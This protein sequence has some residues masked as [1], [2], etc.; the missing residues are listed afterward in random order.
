[1]KQSKA[2]LKSKVKKETEIGFAIVS[3]LR[4]VGY[5]V[6][7]EV[8]IGNNY[9]D[10]VAVKD[11]TITAIELKISFSLD[12]IAQAKDLLPNFNAVYVGVGFS[13]PSRARKLAMEICS[14]FGIGVI[15]VSVS[16]L[17][18]GYSVTGDLD[19]KFKS[20]NFY[21]KM[22]YKLKPEMMD[23][24]AAGS[25]NSKRFTPFQETQILL[26]DYVKE[27][28]GTTIIRAVSSIRHHY[29][30]NRSAVISIRERIKSG[31]IKSLVIRNEENEERLYAPEKTF[32][33]I[34]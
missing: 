8:P 10:I 25:Q 6:Y 11:G 24:C 34:S 22:K 9:I 15:S 13:S 31:V 16:R 1:M 21:Q 30:S 26:T 18:G 14:S 5:T 23:F 3:Y 29:S 19:P 7:Q 32:L 28:P 20:G 12:V 33:C 17:N 2:Y 27:N 4:N